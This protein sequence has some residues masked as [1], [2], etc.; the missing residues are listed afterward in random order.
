[1]GIISQQSS[2]TTQSDGYLPPET[3]KFVPKCT[4]F[5][6]LLYTFGV[7]NTGS[8]LGTRI[9]IDNGKY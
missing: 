7:V 2:I 4:H 8:Q 6:Y 9:E 5:L 3:S 1:M